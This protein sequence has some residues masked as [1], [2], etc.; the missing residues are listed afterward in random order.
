VSDMDDPRAEALLGEDLHALLTDPAA[1][2]PGP[3]QLNRM[4]AR[5]EEQ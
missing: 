5:L 4:L 2:L 1:V 3:A